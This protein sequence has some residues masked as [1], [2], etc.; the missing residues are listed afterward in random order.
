MGG[1]ANFN[2]A[3]YL[4]TKADSF[5]SELR[6]VA[7]RLLRALSIINSRMITS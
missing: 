7:E 6:Q 2:K 3:F 5:V 1:S 4:P